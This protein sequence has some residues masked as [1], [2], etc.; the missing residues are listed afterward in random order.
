MILMGNSEI[1]EKKF[2][3]IVN[4][5]LRG[6]ITSKNL[7]YEEPKDW[8]DLQLKVAKIY[9]NLGCK[10]E[11]DVFVEGLRTKHKIDVWVIFKFGGLEYRIITECKYWNT[12]VKKAQVG[13][14]LGVLADIG[15]E[16]GIIVSKKGFQPGAHRLASYTNI[17][18]FTFREL[19]E[20]SELHI[21][22]FKI[23][24]ILDKIRTLSIPF[25]RFKWRM[26]EETEKRDLWWYPSE[27]GGNFSSALSLLRSHVENMDLKTFPR[28][29]IYSFVARR[30]EEVW[31][32]VKNRKEY[33]NC[34]LDNL[35]IL[36]KEYEKYKKE[37]FSE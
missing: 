15:A 11:V 37:I 14:L 13:T 6:P 9:R 35:K 5:A 12:K 16:K 31:K 30:E 32:V 20:K 1:G 19:T 26:R 33:L 36:E 27:K 3:E 10:T 22:H 21:D 23:H 34:V 18:L 8:K 4:Y 17:D 24:S 25:L 7:D 29:Y 2:K 28:G